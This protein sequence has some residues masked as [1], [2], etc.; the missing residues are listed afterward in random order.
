MSEFNT[1]LTSYLPT[2]IY[3]AT[4][5]GECS[6]DYILPDTVGDIKRVLRVTPRVMLMSQY[7][8]SGRLDYGGK[9]VYSALIVTENNKLV[10]LNYEEPFEDT[11]DIDGLT[12]SSTVSVIPEAGQLTWRMVNQRKLGIKLKLRTHITATESRDMTPDTGDLSYAEL[13]RDELTVP[14]VCMMSLTDG[15]VLSEDIELE[16][17]LPQL[18]EII[19]VRVE[20][21]VGECK[22]G[23][24]AVGCRGEAMVSIL[25]TSDVGEPVFTVKHVPFMQQVSFD[26]ATP[27]TQAIAWAVCENPTCE[28]KPNGYGEA[29][30]V[31]LDCDYTLTVECA[32]S[33]P[34]S[35]VRDIYSTERATNVDIR[36]VTTTKFE[37]GYTT[38]FSVNS[39]VAR[40]ESPSLDADRVVDADVR[41]TFG[42]FT[43]DASRS[44]IGV[45]GSAEVTVTTAKKDEGGVNDYASHTFTVPVKCELDGRF[46][47][48]MKYRCVSSVTS[49]RT[50]LDSASVYVDFE[51]A[52]ALLTMCEE[53]C[54]VVERAASNPNGAQPK[55][56]SLVLC[57]PTE[58]ETLWDI[59]KRYRTTCDKIADANSLAEGERSPSFAVRKKYK[60]I[61]I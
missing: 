36:E 46:A 37:R 32:L 20:M 51:V 60:V 15:G 47:E 11:L 26:G 50:R 23:G 38:N 54:T 14:A 9:A 43:Q 29:R 42:E 30:V 17:S 25:Y 34:V 56:A 28:I 24:G 41:L 45:E 7:A 19:D 22:C 52:L 2:E 53:R 61:M 6:G 39:S 57:Y 1:G 12:P 27:E 10:R 49:T 5:D 16:G 13:E 40:N 55:S 21:N 31:A 58:G 44:K 8:D 48:G 3:K 4:V 59:A 35:M 33:E 18:G